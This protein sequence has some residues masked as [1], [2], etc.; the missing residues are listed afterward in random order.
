MS[1]MTIRG[2][3]PHGKVRFMAVDEPGLIDAEIK[4]EI[5]AMVAAGF[6]IDRVTVE[7]ARKSDLNCEPCD[8]EREKGGR[9]KQ[10]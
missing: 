6:T 10:P 8:A 9:K 7:E 4:R 5:G 2:I 3:C 1:L